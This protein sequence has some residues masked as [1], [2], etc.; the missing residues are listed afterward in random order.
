VVVAVLQQFA[1]FYWGVGDLVVVLLLA[2][3]LLL[4]PAG[5]LGKKVH[6]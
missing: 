4:R 5:I 6:A 1:N 2:G 3:V